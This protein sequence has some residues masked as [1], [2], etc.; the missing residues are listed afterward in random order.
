MHFIWYSVEFSTYI[1]ILAYVAY[2]FGLVNPFRMKKDV[3]ATF[4]DTW[5]DTSYLIKN[6][7]GF[8]KDLQGSLTG[9]V[10]QKTKKGKGE[11]E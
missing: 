6:A 3:P 1:A 9:E 7:S 10:S 5:K 2:T 11:E 8:V 4:N